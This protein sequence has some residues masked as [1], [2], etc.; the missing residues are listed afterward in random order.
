MVMAACKREDFTPY[1]NRVY[2]VYDD[3]D[4]KELKWQLKQLPGVCPLSCYPPPNPQTQCKLGDEELSDLQHECIE[5]TVSGVIA[6]FARKSKDVKKLLNEVERLFKFL[7]V[8]PASSATAERS[9]ST[10]R[11]L[12]NYLRATMAQER[13]NHVAVLHVH[14]TRVDD[15]DVNKL[16]QLFISAN[17]YRRSVFGQKS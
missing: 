2:E 11:R 17:D 4:K 12:K 10:L 6:E 5:V 16:K 13:L 7:L 8:V 14:K 1:L 15:L 3:F 9:F